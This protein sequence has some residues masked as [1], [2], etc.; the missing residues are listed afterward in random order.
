[1]INNPDFWEVQHTK[2]K[3]EAEVQARVAWARAQNAPDV[4]IKNI[5]MTDRSH[6]RYISVRKFK[7]ILTIRKENIKTIDGV[8]PDQWND[9]TF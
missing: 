6:T 1:M 8:P 4:V 9:R 3:S 7:H 2:T 5:Q